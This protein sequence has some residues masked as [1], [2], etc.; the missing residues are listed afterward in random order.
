MCGGKE[1]WTPDKIERVYIFF[2]NLTVLRQFENLNY[3]NALYM[4]LS[5][6]V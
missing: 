3:L 1:F 2:R 6:F 4:Y 5:N